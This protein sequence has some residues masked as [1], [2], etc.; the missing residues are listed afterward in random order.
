MAAPTRQTSTAG[1][2]PAFPSRPGP[3]TPTATTTTPTTRPRRRPRPAP[4][5]RRRHKQPTAPAVYPRTTPQAPRRW[6]EHVPKFT[7]RHRERVT[8]AAPSSSTKTGAKGPRARKR[9][10]TPK[11]PPTTGALVAIWSRPGERS[12]VSPRVRCRRSA[13]YPHPPCSAA[14]S[15]RRRDPGTGC[16]ARSSPRSQLRS[17]PTTQRPVGSSAGS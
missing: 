13:V 16:R 8:P 2:S 17:R 11:R 5:H 10:P 3:N 12:G 6:F 15:T 1:T 14:D 4:Y 9:R 7:H